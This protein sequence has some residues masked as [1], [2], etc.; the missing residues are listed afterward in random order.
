MR[1]TW[2]GVLSRPG[3][4]LACCPCAGGLALSPVLEG[5]CC[6]RSPGLGQAHALAL[7][8]EL[9]AA[10][11]RRRRWRR[12]CHEIG[13]CCSQTARRAGQ[14]VSHQLAVGGARLQLVWRKALQPHAHVLPAPRGH[15]VQPHLPF[16]HLPCI[17]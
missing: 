12:R 1:A 8:A 15:P 10:A 17:L 5:S 11:A 9:E 3:L 13:G 6:P 14:Q 2:R 7:S 16:L 4:C